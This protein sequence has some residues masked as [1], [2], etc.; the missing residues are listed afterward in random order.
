ML[1]MTR[2]K[3]RYVCM[4]FRPNVRVVMIKLVSNSLDCT[5]TRLQK[6]ANIVFYTPTS[7][8]SGL[9]PCLYTLFIRN[10]VPVYDRIS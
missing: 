6:I 5:C 7:K 8:V 9:R 1:R 4:L 10:R 3:D 2:S